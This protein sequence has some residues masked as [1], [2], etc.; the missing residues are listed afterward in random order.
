MRFFVLAC[1]YDGTIAHDGRVSAST[2]EALKRIVDTGRRLVLVT[3]RELEDLLDIF[4]EIT[5]FEWVVAENGA[6]LYRPS[7]RFEKLLADPPP[8]TFVEGLKRRGVAPI[9]VGRAIVATWEPHQTTVLQAIRDHGLELQVIFNK[10]A[11]MILP[12]AV[13]KATGLIAALEQ[14]NLSQ[15]EVVGVGDA[16]NDHA[17]LALCEC[18]AAVANA[19]PAVKQKA[20]LALQRDHGDGV[21]DL[22]DDLVRGDLAPI[23]CAKPI[24]IG[25]DDDDREVGIAPFGPSV[26]IAG[27]SGSGKSTAN[28]TFLERLVECHYQFCIIDPE[29]DYESLK[30]AITVGTGERGPSDAEVLQVLGHANQNV[31]VNLI[32][33]T[34]SERPAFFS[35]LLPQLVQLREQTSRPHWLIVDEA[36]HLMPPSWTLGTTFATAINRAVLITVHPDQVHPEI[37]STVGT[38]IAVGADAEK[39]IEQFCRSQGIST[40]P[41]PSDIDVERGQVVY[42]EVNGETPPRRVRIHPNTVQRQR[43]IRK[44]AEGALPEERS[45]Y[46]RGREGKLNLRA[47]NLMLFLQLADGIDDETWQ[48]HLEQGDYSQWFRTCIKDEELANQ[49]ANVERQRLAPAESR[50]RLREAVEQLYTLPTSEARLSDERDITAVLPPKSE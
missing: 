31:V 25:L 38:V 26:L 16:E 29:G 10:G 39:T 43:H 22:I 37:L 6:L 20:H 14:M 11:V 42:W 48:F 1:D 33:M 47:Q 49:A 40:P 17:F 44:Y 7:D 9:S 5:L 15:H 34:L 27:P 23:Q 18:S 21:A 24:A 2:V 45:F 3:G 12:A 41:V 35:K 32:G 46:F 36:H 19:L 8:A 13:N 28:T 50:D 30:F 4:P